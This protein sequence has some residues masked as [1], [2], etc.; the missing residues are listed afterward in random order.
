M[1]GSRCPDDVILNLSVSIS[2]FASL[3]FYS[4]E[5][6]LILVVRWLP[7]AGG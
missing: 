6:S 5:D 4:Q 3:S 2:C 7:A 1:V